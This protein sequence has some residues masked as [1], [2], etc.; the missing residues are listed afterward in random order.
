MDICHILQA[1]QPDLFGYQPGR[2]MRPSTPQ[3]GAF[4]WTPADGQVNTYVVTFLSEKIFTVDAIMFA[5]NH[6]NETVNIFNVGSEDAIDATGIA[7]IVVE[8]MG[9]KDVR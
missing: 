5:I 1:S 4:S 6:I 3:Q 2:Q 7:G 9:L 8:E